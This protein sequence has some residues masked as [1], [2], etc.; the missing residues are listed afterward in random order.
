[1]LQKNS[2]ALL[3][4]KLIVVLIHFTGINQNTGKIVLV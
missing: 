1:M 4:F 2:S 3:L